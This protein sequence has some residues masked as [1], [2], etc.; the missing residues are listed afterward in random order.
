MVNKGLVKLHDPIEKY[1]SSSV[2]VPQYKGHKIIIEDLATHTSALPEWPA[3]YCPFFNPAD[4]H[5]INDTIQSRIKEM[6]CTKNYTFDQLYKSFSNT[7]ITREPDSKF[8]YSTFGS[9]LLG[10]ILTLKSNMSSFDK[11]LAYNI[12]DVLGINSTS[13]GLSDSQKSRLAI[14]HFNGHELPT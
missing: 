12:V 4:R 13:I 8:E 3:N 5:P 11:L 9:G 1:L 14:G 2:T 6:N 7:T 10:R